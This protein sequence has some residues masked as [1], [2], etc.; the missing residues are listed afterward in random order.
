MKNFGHT[1][2][3]NEKSLKFLSREVTKL[4]LVL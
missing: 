3:I 2:I 4:D 1:L